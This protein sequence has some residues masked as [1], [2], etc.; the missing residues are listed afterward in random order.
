MAAN[1]KEPEAWVRMMPI[2][3]P[4]RR[5]S[6]TAM[7]RMI[8]GR[9]FDEL[10]ND[11][12]FDLSEVA[13]RELIRLGIVEWG[14]IF[15]AKGKAVELTPDRETRFATAND[16][17]RPTGTID[18]LLEEEDLF[19]KLDAEYVVPDAKRRAEKNGLSASPAGTGEAATRGK[20]TASSAAGA[21]GTAGKRKL[22]SRGRKRPPD[23][24]AASNARTS[25]TRSK[26]KKRKASGRS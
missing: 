23:A 18:Q 8:A 10:D 6:Q 26:A 22:R 12:I 17:N 21:K 9:E 16:P 11:A 25:N 14:G 1:G 15:D 2:T 4:M 7:R 19:E 5:R 20:G 13:S 24:P 3:G